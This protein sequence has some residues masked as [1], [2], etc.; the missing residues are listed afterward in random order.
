MEL[1]AAMKKQMEEN[2]EAFRAL[3]PQEQ[4]EYKKAIDQGEMAKKRLAE[5]NLRLVVKYCKK[6]CR[7]RNV[8]LRPYTGR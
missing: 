7:K 4:K 3:S 5:A 6:I 8:I 1:G 2:I